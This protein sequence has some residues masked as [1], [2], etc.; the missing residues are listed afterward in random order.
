MFT[1]LNWRL[2]ALLAV[3]LFAVVVVACGG[4]SDDSGESYFYGED[5][6]TDEVG[7]SGGSAAATARPAATAAP[8]PEAP[9]DASDPEFFIP[10][11]GY[12]LSEEQLEKLQGQAGGVDSD[13]GSKAGGNEL[14]NEIAS[15]TEGR[16]IIRT[17]DLSLVV[18][19]VPTSIDDITNIAT[20][21]GGWVV[22]SQLTQVFRGSISIRVPAARFDDVVE[23][24]E[25]LSTDINFVTTTSQDFTEEFTDTT[26][27][28]ETLRDTLERLQILYERAFSVED[29]ITIQKEI[30]SVQG[31]IEALE[32]RLSF[33]SQSSAFSLISVFLEAQPITITIDAGEDLRAAVHHPTMFRAKFTPPEGFEEF[34]VV[35]DFGD[36]FGEQ[37]VSR[38]VPTGNGDELVTAPVIHYYQRDEDSPFIV[39]AKLQAS[40]DAGLAEGEDTLVATVSQLPVIEVFAGEN[41]IVEYKSGVEFNGSFTRPEGITDLEYTWNFGDGSAPLTFALA[42]DEESTEINATHAF[43]NFRPNA[44]MVTLTI[45]GQ[46]EVGEVE[47]TGEVWV[48]VRESIGVASADLDAGSTVRDAGRTLGQIGV[49]VLEMGLWI[50]I[51]SPAWII[52]LAILY[53]VVRR[54]RIKVPAIRKSTD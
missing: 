21:S 54:R 44:Y 52:G 46:T 19:S 12:G 24:L 3:M 38:V 32:A 42:D 16:V 30:T 18:E 50:A 9:V 43:Q 6:A 51:L 23:Q 8:A 47:A 29:A 49:F 20:S 53:F 11:S 31:D 41:Q 17:G 35:W 7:Y 37:R 14:E 36:G 28:A 27:R 34:S 13:S 4:G 45:T 15:A 25:N 48:S 33:L 1:R 5:S 26:A 39:T 2:F 10:D 40:G 22:N